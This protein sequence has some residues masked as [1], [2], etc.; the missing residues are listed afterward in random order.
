[1]E[2]PTDKPFSEDQARF[3]FQDLLKGIGYREC[4]FKKLFIKVMSDWIDFLEINSS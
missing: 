4:V 2:V 3:Y 1:M